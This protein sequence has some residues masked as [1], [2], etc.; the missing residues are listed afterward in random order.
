VPYS[1]DW[2]DRLRN[3]PGATAAELAKAHA[4]YGHL[5]GMLARQ[6]L[7]EHGLADTVQAVASHGHTLFHQPQRQFTFQLGCGQ[8]LATHVGVPV[9]SDF[10]TA[11]VAL[12][13]QGAPLVPFAE[14]LLWPEHEL[15]LNLG[16]I[17]NQSILPRTPERAQALLQGTWLRKP[18][19]CLGFDVCGC[20]QLLNSAARLH[21]RTL[22]YDPAGEVAR[23]GTVLPELLQALLAQDYH[24]LPPPKSLGNEDVR[25]VWQL[26]VHPH[27][28]P[29]ADVLC[30]LVEYTAVALHTALA[31]VPVL[32]GPM[33]VTGGGAHNAYLVERISAHVSQ[34][35][36]E[37]VVPAPLVVDYK[38]ALAFALLGMHTL[39]GRPNTLPDATSAR[40][41]VCAGSVHRP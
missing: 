28:A 6:F 12:G 9:V 33:L 39:L 18:A 13:G 24:H 37:V 32:N 3:L 21:D 34:L 10:R 19:P 41:T 40:R 30:T 2:K 7:V 29:A 25:A 20:N 38:E 23:S 15:F 4:D 1:P 36:I 17:A 22:S 27:S 11:D 31:R 26:L 16:G 8:T 14:R 35:G 5:L